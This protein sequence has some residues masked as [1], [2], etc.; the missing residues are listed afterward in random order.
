MDTIMAD[1]ARLPEDLP[2]ADELFLDEVV[3][4]NVDSFVPFNIL[5]RHPCVR[6]PANLLEDAPTDS[7]RWRI[8]DF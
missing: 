3:G 1:D 6:D 2:R 4:I 7:V 8:A 5:H